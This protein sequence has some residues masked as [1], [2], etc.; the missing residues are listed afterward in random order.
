[1]VTRPGKARQKKGAPALRHG[2]P[3]FDRDQLIPI[4]R[5]A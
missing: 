5:K 1:M 2:A 4:S 3:V